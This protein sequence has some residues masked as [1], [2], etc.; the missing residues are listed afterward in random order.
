MDGLWESVGS[1]VSQLLCRC[2]PVLFTDCNGRNGYT[3]D[4]DG[5][6]LPTESHAIGRCTPEVENSNREAFHKLLEQQF[7]SSVNSVLGPGHTYFGNVAGV[8]SRIDHVCMPQSSA[9]CSGA[10]TQGSYAGPYGIQ[11]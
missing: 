4:A 9:T 6:L 2:V 10:R 5:C 7:M 3:R 1:T 8:P 11:A